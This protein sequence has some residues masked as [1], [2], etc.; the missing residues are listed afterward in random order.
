M[1]SAAYNR[2]RWEMRDMQEQIATLT[3]ERD[4]ARAEAAKWRRAFDIKSHATERYVPCPDCRDK[5]QAGECLRCKVQAAEAALAA[6]REAAGPAIRILAVIPEDEPDDHALWGWFEPG[7]GEAFITIGD[8]RRLRAL[9][10]G[11][12]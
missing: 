10:Q 3:R 1:S 8:L 6:L 4:E 5:V 2:A 7:I 9:S 12:G 11:E